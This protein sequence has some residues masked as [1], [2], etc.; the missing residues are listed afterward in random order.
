M[1]IPYSF[2]RV[3]GHTKKAVRLLQCNDVMSNPV[4]YISVKQPK[5]K[6]NEDTDRHIT[7]AVLTPQ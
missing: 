2:N 4:I 3:F 7:E 6:H 5:S 1:I